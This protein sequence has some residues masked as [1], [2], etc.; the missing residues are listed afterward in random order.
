MKIT[1]EGE[2]C[3]GK[4][5]VIEIIALTLKR[6]GYAVTVD[7]KLVFD[8]LK[9]IPRDY[10]WSLEEPREVQIVE[11]NSSEDVWDGQVFAADIGKIKYQSRQD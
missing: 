8:C 10:V 11:R 6:L 9:A 4:S 1:I 3:E 5:T 7:N 2:R